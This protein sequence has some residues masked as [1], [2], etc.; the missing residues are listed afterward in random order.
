MTAGGG[1]LASFQTATLSN[2]V[3]CWKNF[4]PVVHLVARVGISLVVV[5]QSSLV[6][7]FINKVDTFFITHFF[8]MLC[9]S[10]MQGGDS[11]SEHW[12]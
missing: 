5:T 12:C 7:E 11:G 9:C 10:A 3:L 6:V 2:G 1:A 4:F 8:L